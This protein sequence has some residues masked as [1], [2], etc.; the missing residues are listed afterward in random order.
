M[1]RGRRG[2]ASATLLSI[3]GIAILVA[4]GTWQVLR[5][6][7]KES[8]IASLE[9]RLAAEPLDG[10]PAGAEPGAIEYR[11]VRLSGVFLHDEAMAVL[12]RT[13]DGRLGVHVVTPF[14]LGPDWA[15]L[16]DRGWAPA[17][18]GANRPVV[19]LRADGPGR[20]VVEGIIRAAGRP[21]WLVP[22][23]A[24]ERDQWYYIDIPAMAAHAGLGAVAPYY[25]AEGLRRDGYPA[26]A[27]AGV[28]L[29]NEHLG[30][31]LTWYGLAA[32][33]ASVYLVYR[34]RALRG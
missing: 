30:Y 11:R 3:A 15:V 14:G 31:A 33:L 19:E 8:L 25:I 26:G 34:R 17:D 21:G 12:N 24:P 6:G 22:D 10:L 7:W 2:L 4:L 18:P 29:R 27:M 1:A 5:L 9:E 23:N 16:V 32:A 28:K 13:L 20:V